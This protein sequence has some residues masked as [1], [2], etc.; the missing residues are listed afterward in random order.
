GRVPLSGVVALR[1]NRGLFV[2]DQVD[3]QTPQTKLK[4]T[5]QF[6]FDGDSDL[7]VDL[8]SA[9]AAELQAVLIS[10]GL[11]PDVEEQMRSYGVA[12]GGQLAFNGTLKGKLSSPDIDGKVSL[13]SLLVNGHDLG[14]VSAALKMTADELRITDGRL[15]EKD[16]GGMQF[17]L[18]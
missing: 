14:S 13:G 18:N 8:N 4:A 11:L 3:L 17:T 6:A 1:A 2:I 5:G 15:T 9:D 7:Q 12:L 16:G 10:S